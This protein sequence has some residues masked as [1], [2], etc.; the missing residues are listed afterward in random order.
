MQDI[1]PWG[2]MIFESHDILTVQYKDGRAQDKVPFRDLIAI[3][4]ISIEKVALGRRLVY[5]K[6][7][8]AKDIGTKYEVHQVR[9]KEIPEHLLKDYSVPSAPS[10][11]SVSKGLNG[12]VNFH[13][14]VSVRSGTCEAEQYY[15]NVVHPVFDA[16]GLSERDYKTHHTTTTQSIIEFTENVV[17]PRANAGIAQTILLLSGDGGVVDIVNVLLQSNQ[18]SSFVKPRVGLI[19]LGTGNAL[20][21]STGLNRDSSKGLGDFL[22]GHPH[23]VPTLTVR[24]STNSKLLV[25]EGRQTE[26][27]PTDCSGAGVVH[28]AVVCSWGLHASLVA[29]S[30]TS[31]YRKYGSQRFQM[32]AKELLDPSDGSEPHHYKGRITII[33]RDRNGEESAIEID[34]K[35]HVYI[36]ATLV[37]SLQ[38]G[39]TISP[40]TK[41]LDR[42]LRLIH[43]EVLPSDEIMRILGL[44]FAGGR[45]IGENTVNYHEIEGLRIEFEEPDSRWR[46]ICVDGKII[47][48]GEG[49]WMEMRREARDVLDLIADVKS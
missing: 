26:T 48:V 41:P 19:A 40:H 43:F 7:K 3:L 21:N 11:I 13:V 25:N 39:F 6:S 49:G 47:S 27:L 17:S 1:A 35:E 31:E 30:D 42:Q 4:P 44:A 24:F 10:H 23:S 28:G 15:N 20:A 5:I 36:L 34:R 14:I 37:S 45:H 12:E 33:K 38:Q 46:R 2:E 32:A 9:I 29:D 22:R 8:E 16:L 18:S